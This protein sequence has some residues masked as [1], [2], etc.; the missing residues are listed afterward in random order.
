M[1]LCLKQLPSSKGLPTK[2]L[3]KEI[4]ER[5]DPH[6]VGSLP[7]ISFS[8]TSALLS[9]KL[10]FNSINLINRKVKFPFK[11]KPKFISRKCLYSA[12]VKRR[13]KL[14]VDASEHFSPCRSAL[15]NDAQKAVSYT[16]LTLPTNREV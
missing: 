5:L 8:S 3:G 15:L 13:L 10:Q 14:M 16:H 9:S 1:P 11:R 6:Q 7:K 2:K 12:A 4:L